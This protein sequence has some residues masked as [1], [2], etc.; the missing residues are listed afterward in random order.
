MGLAQILADRPP[1]K[2]APTPGNLLELILAII[3]AIAIEPSDML[4]IG[5][6]ADQRLPT[7]LYS[8][9]ARFKSSYSSQGMR[10]I[11]SRAVSCSSA[12]ARSPCAK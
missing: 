8:A 11:R 3:A 10:Q 7:L 1:V 9:I 12:F 2:A 4:D 5:V 6:V